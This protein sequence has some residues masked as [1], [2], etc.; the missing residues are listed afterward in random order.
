ME[1]NMTPRESYGDKPMTSTER[2][3]RARWVNRFEETA[4]KLLD[5]LNEV[6]EPLPRQPVIPSELVEKLHPFIQ[7]G[8][9]HKNK[10]EEVKNSVTRVLIRGNGNQVK[11]KNKALQFI[12]KHLKAEIIDKK[13]VLSEE[14]GSCQVAAYT[15][16]KG[17]MISTPNGEDNN[18]GDALWHDNDHV[19]MFR[20]TGDGRCIIYIS[21]IKPL[22]S[23]RKIGHHGVLW[24]DIEELSS[25]VEVLNSQDVL[26]VLD[27]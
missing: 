26:N 4:F 3:R 20:D 10:K 16:L 19:I 27:S 23:H 24:K 21:K 12:S 22:F 15:D 18:F 2:V 17:A 11:N 25:H 1:K 6:P 9:R 14:W 13:T 7:I 8:N 5:I